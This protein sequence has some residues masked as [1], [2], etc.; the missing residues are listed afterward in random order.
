MQQTPA[1]AKPKPEPVSIPPMVDEKYGS[2]AQIMALP[3][4]R[5]IALLQAPD[6][7]IYAKA[8]AC[9][10]LAVV[11][12]KSA[13]PALAA[14][15]AEPRLSHYARFALE[16][17]PDPSADDALRDA[18]RKTR[19]NLQVGIINSIGRRRDGKAI[20]ALGKL[21]NDRDPEVARAASAALAGIRPAR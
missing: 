10:R 12:D 13:V 15:L 1:P 9:Q 19:G 7:S 16:P 14:L 18:L 5:L 4:D 21:L 3:L 20:P 11:G 2:P 6:A 17:N 8:K